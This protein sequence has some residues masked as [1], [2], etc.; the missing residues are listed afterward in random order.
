LLK[1]FQVRELDEDM[2][3]WQIRRQFL[4]SHAP[5]VLA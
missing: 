2:I 1:L 3:F 5:V 4:T